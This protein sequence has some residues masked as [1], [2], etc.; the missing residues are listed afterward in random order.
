MWK[1]VSRRVKDSIDLGINVRKSFTVQQN[2]INNLKE[3]QQQQQNARAQ[4]HLNCNLATRF[5]DPSRDDKGKGDEKFKRKYHRLNNKNKCF[6]SA[7]TWS[8]AIVTG[9]YASQLLCLYRRKQRLAIEGSRCYYS[10]YVQNTTQ[11]IHRNIQYLLT[12]EGQKS[13]IPSLPKLEC[14][15]KRANLHRDRS[16][17]PKIFKELSEDEFIQLVDPGY[18]QH[19]TFYGNFERRNSQDVQNVSNAINNDKIQYLDD[20]VQ[21][22]LTAE[23]KQEAAIDGAIK[24]LAHIVGELEFQMGLESVLAEDYDGAVDHFTLSSNHNHAGGAFN[25]GLCYE[26]GVGVKRNMKT[27][28]RLYEL[29]SELGHAKAFYNLG[30]FHAHGMGGA[31]KSFRQAKKYFEKAAELGSNDAVGALNLLLPPIKKL[32][33]VEETPDED[34]FFMEKPTMSKTISAM[35]QHSLMRVAVS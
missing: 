11:S 12:P 34:F 13:F 23:E 27:A 4:H 15:F 3:K 19:E 24:E 31:R 33:I 18:K 9:F 14:P 10:K 8:T 30:V 5:Q 17:E 35:A 26:Q 16:T 28:K 22:E 21:K 29:A 32:P 6:M 7:L 25:L 1:Y 2:L 20:S